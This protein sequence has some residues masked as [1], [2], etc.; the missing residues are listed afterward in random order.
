MAYDNNNSGR[1]FKNEFKTEGTKQPDYR[2]DAEVNGVKLKVSGWI[3][4]AKKNGKK[5]ISMRFEADTKSE[6]QPDPGRFVPPPLKS[7]EADDVP[8]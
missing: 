4:T 7:D 3:Q 5:F 8:F 1:L 2:G 6:P